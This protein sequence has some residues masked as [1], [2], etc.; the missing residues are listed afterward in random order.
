M[1]RLRGALC[2]PGLHPL[3]PTHFFSSFFFF[4]WSD[5]EELHCR[6][7]L[8]QEC[9]VR[10][11]TPGTLITHTQA[12]TDTHTQTYNWQSHFP[13]FTKESCKSENMAMLGLLL[14]LSLTKGTRPSVLRMLN[15]IRNGEKLSC[16]SCSAK[17]ILLI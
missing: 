4:R 6:R 7:Q 11:L 9:R 5:D 13:S 15:L 10:M 16:L 14:V 1:G 3:L 2:P 12:C 8:C 17:R